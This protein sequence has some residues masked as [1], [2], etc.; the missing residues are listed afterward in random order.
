MMP[1]GDVPS[2]LDYAVPYP[3]WVWTLDAGNC[4]ILFCSITLFSC[5]S[6]YRPLYPAHPWLQ[7]AALFTLLPFCR[8]FLSSRVG[9]NAMIGLYTVQYDGRKGQGWRSRGAFPFFF[10]LPDGHDAPEAVLLGV[11]AR[12]CRV[13]RLLPH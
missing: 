11:R 9:V 7:P 5:D 6:S 10:C 13:L 12:G 4:G 3:V 1:V 2:P 8:F